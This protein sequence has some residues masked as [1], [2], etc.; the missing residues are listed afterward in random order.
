M[1]NYL[2]I[3]KGRPSRKTLLVLDIAQI[4]PPHSLY[5]PFGQSFPFCNNVLF[6]CSKLSD[7]DNFDS[8]IRSLML[9]FRMSMMVKLP[10]KTHSYC[11]KLTFKKVSNAIW[12]Q[13]THL[14]LEYEQYEQGSPA[15]PPP[16]FG[17]CQKEKVFLWGGPSLPETLKE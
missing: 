3:T 11:E 12:A 14:F 7:N 5:K 2:M 1:N 8:S 16:E 17:Q 10:P 15:P 4:T 9:S 6:R 13:N